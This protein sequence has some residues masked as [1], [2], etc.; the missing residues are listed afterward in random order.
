MIKNCQI[1]PPSTVIET[2]PTVVFV[3]S[4]RFCVTLV[5]ISNEHWNQDD[6]I[7]VFETTCLQIC[8]HTPLWDGSLC[9]SV[10]PV[11]LKPRYQFALN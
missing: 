8:A 7:N 11:E 9:L 2:R 3:H 4:T 1:V 6:T 5:T 10:Y